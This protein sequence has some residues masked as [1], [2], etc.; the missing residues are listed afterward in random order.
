MA[1]NIERLT[2]LAVSRAKEPGYYPDGGGLYLHVTASGVRSWVYR[3]MLNGRAREMGLGPLPDT[4][5]S[6]S[7]SKALEARKLRREGIDPIE[8]RKAARAAARLHAAKTITFRECADAYIR[9]H[10]AG[11]KNAKHA[12]QWGNTLTTY[13]NPVFGSFPVQG[14]DTGL[15]MRV[16][17]GI[18]TE[19]AETAGRLRG[20]IEALPCGTLASRRR[21]R[22]AQPR[23]G[24]MLV[25]VQVSS[26]K[27]RRAGSIRF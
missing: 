9:A 1:R 17:E 21:P 26:M 15:V 6:E 8:H 10:R 23:R 19:K 18:W 11:W 24:A 14:I 2:A 7:R 4:S 27:T 22:G 25:L 12:D 3:F 20:R 13:A 5:L 16:L